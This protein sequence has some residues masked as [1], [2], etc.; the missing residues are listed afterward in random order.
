[1][2]R[3]PALLYLSPALMDWSDMYLACA[4]GL[5]ASVVAQM[6]IAFVKRKPVKKALLAGVDI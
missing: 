1:M 5:A 6:T 2:R 3:R 4:A